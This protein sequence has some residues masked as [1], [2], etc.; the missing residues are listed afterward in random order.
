MS[1]TEQL[2]QD[3][4]NQ[5]KHIQGFYSTF[6]KLVPSMKMY[7]GKGALVERQLSETL[8]GS[9]SVLAQLRGR[10]PVRQ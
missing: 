5:L 10:T 3:E 8:R 4:Q 1:K 2:S 6:D 9:A 7:Q